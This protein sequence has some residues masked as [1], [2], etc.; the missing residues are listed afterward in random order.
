MDGKDIADMSKL[1]K[2]FVR[3]SFVWGGSSSNARQDYIWL[4]GDEPDE[5]SP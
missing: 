5:R 1:V 3:Y 4:G 2:E